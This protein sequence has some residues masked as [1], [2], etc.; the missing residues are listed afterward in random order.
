MPKVPVLDQ[1]Q[2]AETGI[3]TVRLD[4]GAAPIAAFGGGETLGQT[5]EAIQRLNQTFQ[6]VMQEEQKRADNVHGL[7]RF[8]EYSEKR[9][10]IMQELTQRKGE[11][12]FG[13]ANDYARIMDDFDRQQLKLANNERQKLY[14]SQMSAKG[15]DEDLRRLGNHIN[16][17]SLK[18]SERETAAALANEIDRGAKAY[19]DREIIGD[20]VIQGHKYIDEQAV[21][22]GAGP[23][24]IKRAKAEF[25]G[26]MHTS[27]INALINE[28]NST[29]TRLAREHF[30]DH[31]SEMLIE[32]R[33][34]VKANLKEAGVRAV[35]L[36]NITK[37]FDKDKMDNKA[38]EAFMAKITDDE[39]KALTRSLE[40]RE[41]DRRRGDLEQEK[42]Q[43]FIDA[44]NRMELPE[45]LRKDPQTVIPAEIWRTFSKEQRK[46]L[47]AAHTDPPHNPDKFN[48]FNL[49]P[50]SQKARM[51]DDE[52]FVWL[53]NFDTRHQDVA[54]NMVKTARTTPIGSSV[55][56][57]QG[58]VQMKILQ[59]AKI[60]RPNIKKLSAEEKDLR[61]EFIMM[62]ETVQAQKQT[63]L[64][65]KLSSDEKIKLMNQLAA[66]I[67]FQ[68]SAA[69]V[70]GPIT[71]IIARPKETEAP[72]FEVLDVDAFGD[73]FVPIDKVPK[74]NRDFI[75]D[76]AR[77]L[78][79]PVP[80]LAKIEKAYAILQLDLSGKSDQKIIDLLKEPE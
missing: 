2:V 36:A 35:A 68:R 55:L 61:D 1:Q 37:M 11:D 74:R 19:G 63:E 6:G 9:R 53:S 50:Q 49:I 38:R 70:L 42:K 56:N 25:E 62:F 52:L 67:K 24:E 20:A 51:T 23:E 14:I 16:S 31:K 39:E 8:N 30:E 21:I 73:L 12:A 54:V 33:A 10:N 60:I 22:S 46:A 27:V 57:Q 78:G 72:L 64:E 17:E 76:K 26:K 79:L 4:P 44:I 28:G 48:E 5:Q 65:R 47:K 59:K 18:L 7:K 69:A 75:I 41:A 58:K 43:N 3:P 80:S 13:V 32:D 71:S 66:D 40:T 45:N 77:E 34:R 15:R 29:Y